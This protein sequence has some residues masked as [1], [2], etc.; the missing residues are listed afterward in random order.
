MDVYTLMSAE[1]TY[2]ITLINTIEALLQKLRV[3]QK[4]KK[5]LYRLEQVNQALITYE[6]MYEGCIYEEYGE[7]AAEFDLLINEALDKLKVL[8][9]GK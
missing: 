4:D 8:S 9:E 7:K 5:R 2:D 6:R 1:D 3:R